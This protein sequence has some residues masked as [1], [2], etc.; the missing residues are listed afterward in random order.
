MAGEPTKNY[1]LIL[2]DAYAKWEGRIKALGSLAGLLILVVGSAW[3]AVAT[4]LHSAASFLTSFLTTLPLAL[5]A[6]MLAALITRYPA[7]NPLSLA[8]VASLIFIGT[9]LVTK[10]LGIGLHVDYHEAVSSLSFLGPSFDNIGLGFGKVYAFILLFP[11]AVIREY[12]R[13]YGV[14]GFSIST[15]TGVMAGRVVG[16]R[17]E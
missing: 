17:R 10:W 8:F 2:L 5:S 7:D 16:R 1:F 15:A 13:L 3:A 12:F 14:A 4:A 11:F 6:G 9:S